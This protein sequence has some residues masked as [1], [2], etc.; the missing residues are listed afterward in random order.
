MGD[1]MRD[2]LDAW[3]ERGKLVN[4]SCSQHAAER[5]RQRFGI[6]KPYQPLKNSLQDQVRNALKAGRFSRAQPAWSV[7][8]TRP[9]RPYNPLVRWAW[10]E[11]EERA[12]LLI[13]ER[14]C[15]WIVTCLARVLDEVAAQQAAERRAE[16]KARYQSRSQPA[17]A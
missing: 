9:E 1:L 3:L 12:F 7:D 5:A 15:W 8:E 6:R 17:P 16:R 10:D 2:D 4:V 11:K 14:R 13:Y